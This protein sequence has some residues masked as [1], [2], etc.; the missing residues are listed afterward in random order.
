[1]S[2]ITF[3]PS[4]E[5]INGNVRT[6]SLKVAEH[7]GKRHD[8]VLRAIQ[9]LECSDD[10]KLRNFAEVTREVERPGRGTIACHMYEM[11]RDGF[12]FV[13]MGF[14]GKEAARWKEAY[15]NAFNRM[16]AELR[17]QV[18]HPLLESPTLTASEQ[19][20]LSEIVARRAGECAEIGKAKAEIWSRV[21]RKFR[22][23][24]Y[25]QLPR[26]QLSDAIAYVMQMDIK[27]PKE[28]K[29]TYSA[30]LSL[31]QLSNRAGNRGW[32]T[33]QEMAKTEAHERPLAVLL[34][35]ITEDGHDVAGAQAEYSAIKLL[36]EVYYWRLATLA[37]VFERLDRHGLNIAQH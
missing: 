1:M 35:Q 24:K 12:T 9:N 26:E 21:H 22:V 10:F 23:A 15:I 28:D 29:P 16:E 3:I 19:Q 2:E 13:A 31:W 18:D 8:T 11:T 5:I 30:P 25:Q 36:L 27:T 20:T 37:D 17:G 14:T 33:Y 34:R 6:T 4:V 32:M 7:F